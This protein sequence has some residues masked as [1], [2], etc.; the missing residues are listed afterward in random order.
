MEDWPE[1]R[2]VTDEQDEQG[3]LAT[4]MTDLMEVKVQC[5][6]VANCRG[7]AIALLAAVLLLP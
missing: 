2:K 6:I 4:F 7:D 3:D 1:G 5:G